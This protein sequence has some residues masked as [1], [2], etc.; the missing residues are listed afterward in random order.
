MTGNTLT[1]SVYE[2]LM[3][4]LEDLIV[5]RTMLDGLERDQI[6][7]VVWMTTQVAEKV[8]AMLHENAECQEVPNYLRMERDLRGLG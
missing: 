2:Y 7:V 8:L 3:C 4:G 1:L 6:D 5:A